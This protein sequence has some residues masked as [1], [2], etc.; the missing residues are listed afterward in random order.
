M[1][2]TSLVDAAERETDFAKLLAAAVDP[3]VEMCER[4]ADLRKSTDG[5][6]D[7]DVFLVNCLEYLVHTLENYPFTAP[8]VRF[9]QKQVQEHVDS[10]TFEHVSSALIDH[11]DVQH[12]KLLEQ[13]GLAPVMKAIRAREEKPLSQQPGAT[14]KEL[15]AA[16]TQFSSFLTSH[17]PLT[18]SRLALLANPRLSETIHRAALKHISEAYSEITDCVTDKKEGYEF[19]ETLLRRGKDEV[20]V[21]LGVTDY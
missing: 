1:Y 7:R 5:T 20:Q 11:P 16:L 10:M 8:R 17:D 18:S 2:D 21:A 19:P 6:W 4:M 9:L 14:S 13:C 15:T 12:G 3:A